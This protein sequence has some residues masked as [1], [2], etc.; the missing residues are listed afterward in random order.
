[1]F[2]IFLLR[3]E[4]TPSLAQLAF[5]TAAIFTL[6]SKVYSPQ[7]V[8]WLAPLG[9][10]ALTR[11]SQRSAFWI[12]QGSEL[13]YHLAI[14]EYLASSSGGARFGITGVA[15]AWITLGRIVSTGY[16]ALK[17]GQSVQNPP[18]EEASTPLTNSTIG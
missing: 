17:I 10:I 5:I 12:W 14:W 16:F 13:L 11:N 18:L 3:I 7:Y 1:V 4:Q 9:V 6:T 2:C 15:Y 8:L